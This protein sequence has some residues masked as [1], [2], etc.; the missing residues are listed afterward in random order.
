MQNNMG[1][2]SDTLRIPDDL[3]DEIANWMHGTPEH[4]D[5]GTCYQY[6]DSIISLF[7]E[8]VNGIKN[9]HTA[10]TP[11]HTVRAYNNGFNT[12]IKAV[13]KMMEASHE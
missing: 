1:K 4:L 5:V 10:N 9:P 11:C 12:A 13:L 6:A 2:K 8:R 3:R 7:Q